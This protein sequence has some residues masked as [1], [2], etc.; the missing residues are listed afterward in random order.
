LLKQLQHGVRV[1]LDK[2]LRL[3]GIS[4]AQFATLAMV[5][6][7]GVA[8]GAEL[9]RRCF[10]TPQTVGTLIAALESVGAIERTPSIDHGRIIEARLTA[11]GKVLLKRA[12]AAALEIE[13]S[14]LKHLTEDGRQA[15]AAILKSCIAHLGTGAQHFDKQGALIQSA[16]I[17][18]KLKRKRPPSGFLE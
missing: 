12:T 17:R 7:L 16:S 4:T 6:E 18:R 11:K 14:Y 2:K 13:D 10:V 3:L 15:F 8:S 9:A 5:E 1:K